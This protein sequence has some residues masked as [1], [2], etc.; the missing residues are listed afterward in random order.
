MRHDDRA[1]GRF[2]LQQLRKRGSAL[3]IQL[4]IEFIEYNQARI[5][6]SE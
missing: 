5:S 1:Q 6:Y 3:L 4:D 2:T